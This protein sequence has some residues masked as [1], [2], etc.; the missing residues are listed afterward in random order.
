MK[1]YL[2]FRHGETFATK[3]KSWYWHRIY[4]APILEEGKPAIIKLGQYLKDIPTDF[5]VCSPFLRCRQTAEIVTGLTG[6]KFE[7]DSRIREYSFEFPYYLK[8]RVLNFLTEMEASDKKT[9]LICTH[10]IIIELIIQYLTKGKL[11]LRER[12]AA[13]LPGVLTIIKNK[14]LKEINFNPKVPKVV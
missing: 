13:P 11:S 9:I 1:T 4:S 6:K 12:L 5:N 3:A 2:I 7:L 10:A 8:K 14:Q